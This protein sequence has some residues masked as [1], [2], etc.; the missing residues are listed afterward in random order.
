[1]F[2]IGAFADPDKVFPEVSGANNTVY[3]AIQIND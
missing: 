2:Y 3:V 1:V